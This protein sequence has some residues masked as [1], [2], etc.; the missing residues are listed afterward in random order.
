[1]KTTTK[2]LMAGFMLACL[3][4]NG[5]NLLSL[6]MTYLT[7]FPTNGN[8][9]ITSYQTVS[10][11][12]YF[13]G[14]WKVDDN[15]YPNDCYNQIRSF[16][17]STLTW[18]NFPFFMPYEIGDANK[19]VYYNNHFYV[20]SGFATG[21]YNGWGSHS[22]LIDINMSADTALETNTLIGGNVWMMMSCTA[23]TNIYIIGGHNGSHLNEILQYSPS[24]SNLNQIT[25]T[26]Y[27]RN[28]GILTLGADGWIYIMG[29]VSAIE[30]FNP[31]TYAVQTMK[32]TMPS[33]FADNTQFTAVWHVPA[34]NSIYFAGAGSRYQT[35]LPIYKYNYSLDILTNTGVFL[36]GTNDT[37]LYYNVGIRDASDPYTAYVLMSTSAATKPSLFKA[38][39]V[40]STSIASMV[41]TTNIVETVLWQY[42]PTVIGSGNYTFGLS[43]APSGMTVDSTSGTISWTPT[44]TQG[45]STNGPITYAVYQSGTTVAWTNF[46]VAVLESNLPPVFLGTPGTQTVYA[47]S[48][49]DVS[50]GATD[51]DIP[52]NMLTYAIVSAPFG[53][54]VNPDTGLVSWTPTTGQVGTSTIYVSV[55]DYNPWAVNSQELSVTNNFS[56]IVK[57]LTPPSFTQSPSNEVVSAGQ[58]FSLTAT[59]MGYPT[60]TYQ[61]QFSANGS[62][63]SNISGATGASYQLSA[64][65][66]TNIGYYRVLAANSVST[67]ASV[68]VSLTFL[69]LNMYA[70][71]NIVG[72]VGA[73]YIVQV[74]PDLSRSKWTTLTNVVLPSQPYI[75]I[76]YNSP[77]NSKQFYRAMPQ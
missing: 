14:G 29:E 42:A 9:G 27:A 67:S 60:P 34:E 15:G 54:D 3:A 56:V 47:T 10:N 24:T 40:T 59:A 32:S 51:S 72:P 37:T 53:V 39:L 2:T 25:N 58:G 50:D 57:G 70:G 48:T 43:N 74:T 28:A 36:P 66:V 12:I 17:L 61:W 30:R 76:D 8:A 62:T 23:N 31:N 75:Y 13:F 18:T 5:G 73:N 6:N 69:N 46:T 21:D 68:S 45:P 49:L 65:G 52:A 19:A 41:Y 77:T 64:S 71:L 22:K 44:E 63:W 38:R 4:A 1:M 7:D 16:N 26:T 35:N 55:T 33:G 11:N 20:T